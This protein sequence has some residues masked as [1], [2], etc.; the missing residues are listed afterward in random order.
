V[1]PLA[2]T[3]AFIVVLAASAW[4]QTTQQSQA[5][6]VVTG[7]VID[8]VTRQPMRGVAVNARSF[9][10][11]QSASHV[12]ASTSDAEGHFVLD[13]LSP[14]RYLIMAMHPGYL[15][16]RISG[17]ASNGRF[18]T[19]APDQHIDGLIV[20]LIPGANIS[21]H[22]KNAD[23]KPM[24][25]VSLEVVKYFYGGS[26]KELRG[27]APPQFTNDDGEYRIAAVAPGKYYI[28]AIA[29]ESPSTVKP[30]TKDTAK[31]QTEPKSDA[32]ATTYYPNST[33]VTNAAP[34]VVRAGQDVAGIDI[35]LTPVHTLSIDGRVL[36]SSSRDPVASAEVTLVNADG[37][38]SERHAT[39]DAK[40][41]FAL[42]NIPPGDYVL[43][44][45]V[46]PSVQ[47]TKMLFGQNAIYIDEKNLTKID[48]L[49]GSGVDISGRIHLDDKSNPDSTKIDLS[50][51]AATL[52]PEGNSLVT[53]LMPEVNGA[54]VRP[55]G[56]FTF[57]DVPV[58]TFSLDLSPLPSGD[59]LKSTGGADVLESGLTVS[60]GQFP[61]PLDLTLSANASQ[62]TGVVL[63][64]QMPA[65][66]TRVVMLPM[67]SRRGQSRF[68]KRS[69][70]DQSGHFSIKS[71]IPG[72][73]K[74][75]ALD[76]LDRT[77]L[78]D[79]DFLEQFEDRG[80]SVHLQEGSIQDVRLN[81]IPTGDATP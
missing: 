62:L 38:S 59:Y 68:F 23:G 34:L 9:G 33:D 19:V 73:Y 70:T 24:A 66:G 49:V 79:P 7:T 13:A 4:A 61:A 55:D 10:A 18:L 60:Q 51:I 52:E 48:V 64:D 21:G 35:A 78:N 17:G 14:G 50:K 69:I 81:V 43:V 2:R 39:T 20:E 26:Q 3:L 44:A 46:E 75:I 58:G 41:S 30:S 47:K 27:V 74:V 63:N 76:G 29:P 6:A 36:L 71:V 65:P 37:S 56:S 1:P 5:T 57:V 8:S 80:E 16:Q 53:A 12:S 67:G 77:T 22:I 31:P 45:R 32:Y 28:R 72:D 15:G 25:H 54:E 40:G 42:A 11:G